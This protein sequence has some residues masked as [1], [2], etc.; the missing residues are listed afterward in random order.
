MKGLPMRG[1]VARV[2]AA[3]GTA[4]VVAGLGT[5]ASGAAASVSHSPV[6]GIQ[7]CGQEVPNCGTLLVYRPFQQDPALQAHTATTGSPVVV[8]AADPAQQLQ[9]WIWADL[10]TVANTVGRRGQLG[11]TRYDIGAYGT[12]HVIRLELSPGGRKSRLCA[13][14]SAGAL[15]LQRCHVS[16]AQ[17]F[18]EAKSANRNGAIVGHYLLSMVQSPNVKGHHEAATGS[19]REGKQVRFGTAVSSD[20]QYWYEQP[21]P[22]PRCP[23]TARFVHACVD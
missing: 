23:V 11:I 17:A 20:L 18:I 3:A 22:P 7:G 9:D 16:A 6:Q 8:M 10:G 5:G 15:V 4:A 12:D 1:L 2:L 19:Y 13:A 21:L 14:F